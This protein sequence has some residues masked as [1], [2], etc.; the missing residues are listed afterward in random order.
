LV[1]RV[2]AVLDKNKDGNISF[3]EFVQGLNSL[4]AGASQEEKL[5]FAFQIY[6]INNDG[7]ISNGELFTVLKMMVG[8]NL[9]DVQLQQLVDRTI[10][11]ADEDFDGKI[12]FEEFCKV[13]IIVSIINLIDGQGL[14]CRRETDNQL[15]RNNC[16]LSTRR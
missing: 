7:F 9:N 6:D 16:S 5:R 1:R 8:S 10:I 12:S 2:I 13:S 3:L 14:G 4:S 11:K 15:L